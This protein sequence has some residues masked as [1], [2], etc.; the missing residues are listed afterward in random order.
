MVKLNRLNVSCFVIVIVLNKILSIMGYKI[1]EKGETT[2]D[3]DENSFK[4]QAKRQLLILCSYH[5]MSKNDF[6]HDF[7]LPF[8]IK[9]SAH[10]ETREVF[11]WTILNLET[12]LDE[13]IKDGYIISS[14]EDVINC[15]VLH[16]NSF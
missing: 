11:N 2:D 4:H 16:T 15:F 14:F 3:F 12:L 5:E 1:T 13:L 6:I 7:E 8:E 10:Q 9:T